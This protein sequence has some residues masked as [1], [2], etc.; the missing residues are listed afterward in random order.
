MKAV[1]DVDARYA[2]KNRLQLAQFQRETEFARQK[3]QIAA[4]GYEMA[5]RRSA[6]SR[7]LGMVTG[8]EERGDPK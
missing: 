8:G 1:A 7:V 3:F 4:A 6:N 5:Q 2:E